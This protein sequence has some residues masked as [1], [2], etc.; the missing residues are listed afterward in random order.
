MPITPQ[1]DKATI[2]D[3]I[4][5]DEYILSLGFDGMHTYSHKS[6]ADKLESDNFQIFIYN[7]NSRENENNNLTIM[8]VIQID[9]S[10]PENSSYKADL[11]IQQ[12]IALL[13]E[14]EWETHSRMELIA[15]S[16]CEQTCQSG[17]YTVAARF[18]YCTTTITP[19]HT[20]SN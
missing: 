16:P 20:I 13:N 4:L 5:A 6:T 14:Y 17:F 18:T 15:P 7:V 1:E 9:V 19:K 3:I 11:A 12:I 2:R 8:P 10:V